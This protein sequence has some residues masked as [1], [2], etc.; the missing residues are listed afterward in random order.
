MDCPSMFPLD[1]W[2]L[3][4]FVSEHLICWRLRSWDTRVRSL[5][6]AEEDDLSSF[7]SKSLHGASAHSKLNKY[8]CFGVSV[9][10]CLRVPPTSMVRG[11]LQHRVSQFIFIR[12]PH[13]TLLHNHLV[14]RTW[15]LVRGHAGQRLEDI[16]ALDDLA[17]HDV[18]AVQ[19]PGFLQ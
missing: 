4:R 17:E 8:M 11:A 19:E 1:P 9:V 5:V 15:H 10:P 13:T 3:S 6:T 18:P 7:H 16:V 2:W 12:M 14:A